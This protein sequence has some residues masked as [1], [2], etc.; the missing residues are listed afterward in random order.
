MANYAVAAVLS[1]P[2][3]PARGSRVNPNRLKETEMKKI[4]FASLTLGVTL[5]LAVI[6]FTQIF[7]GS[8]NAENR[9]RSFV[10]MGDLRLA[11]SQTNLIPL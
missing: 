8:S 5:V 2:H 3:K 7:V 4:R 11:E 6:A 9:S 1:C 10:G